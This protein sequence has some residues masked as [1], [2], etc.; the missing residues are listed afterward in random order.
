MTFQLRNDTMCEEIRGGMFELHRS[1]V[2]LG[3]LLEDRRCDSEEVHIDI[4]KRCR[5]RMRRSSTN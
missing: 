4:G 3:G 1:L 5:A 2:C